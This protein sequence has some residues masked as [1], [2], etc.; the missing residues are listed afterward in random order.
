MKPDEVE[1][2]INNGEGQRTEFKKS[3]AE[4][5][6]AIRTLC[7]FAN[8]EGGTVYFGIT[9]EGRI[10]GVDLGR[11]PIENFANADR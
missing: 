1:K 11:N 6:E 2:I 4:E 9:D 5:D 7:A 3:F 8:A 10:T